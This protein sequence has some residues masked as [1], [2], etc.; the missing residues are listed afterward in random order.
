MTSGELCDIITSFSLFISFVLFKESSY[1]IG[2]IFFGFIPWA[3]FYYKK[4]NANNLK[5]FDYYKKIS[6][7]VIII[8]IGSY[9]IF[10]LRSEYYRVFIVSYLTLSLIFYGIYIFYVYPKF[11][12]KSDEENAFK[13]LHKE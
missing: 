1:T 5:Y 4:E 10:G 7:T 3:L 13:L 6:T 12:R 8:F 11:I 2:I 9:F